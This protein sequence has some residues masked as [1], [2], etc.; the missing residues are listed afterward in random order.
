MQNVTAFSLTN[1]TAL[2]T[3][4]ATTLQR[5]E[6]PNFPPTLCCSVPHFLVTSRCTLTE[7]KWNI[8][9]STGK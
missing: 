4:G 5:V 6:F 9:V 3:L 1:H 7:S 2:P 8:A